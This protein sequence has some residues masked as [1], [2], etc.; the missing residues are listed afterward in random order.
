MRLHPPLALALVVV[1]G[2]CATES[3]PAA[4]SGRTASSDPGSGSPA[5]SQAPTDATPGAEPALSLGLPDESDPRAVAFTVTPD[6]PPDGD[7]TITVTVTNESD[8]R[9]DELVLRWPTPLDEVLFLAP[10]ARDPARVVDGG[11]PLV[12][13]W[14]KWVVGPGERDEPE[15]TTSLGWGPL[16]PGATVEI[17]IIVTRRAAGPV[18]FDLQ[19][20]AGNAILRMGGSEPAE[21]RVEIP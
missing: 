11:P 10:F 7:G 13:P 14:T 3:P 16:D 17:P 9:I 19:V 4:G 6:V 21:V 2:A 8:G 20:L 1:L 15:G 5:V 18:Q 12:Q